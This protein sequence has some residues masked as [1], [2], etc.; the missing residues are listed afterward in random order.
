MLKR[1]LKGC[2]FAMI[3]YVVFA[4]LGSLVLSEMFS[5]SQ[6]T[7]L[8]MTVYGFFIVGPIAAIAAFWYGVRRPRVDASGS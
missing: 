2:A 7:N 6:D 3:A 4:L 8:E 5:H 1:I